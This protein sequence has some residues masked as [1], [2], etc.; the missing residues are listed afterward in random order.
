MFLALFAQACERWVVGG[1][2]GKLFLR[3]LA[4]ILCFKL[5]PSGAW[6]VWVES[7]GKIYHFSQ[8]IFLQ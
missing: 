8:K 1:W 6:A 3:E 7:P 2:L 5:C 4:S